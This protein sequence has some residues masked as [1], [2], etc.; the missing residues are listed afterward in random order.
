MTTA[1][2]ITTITLN[3]AIDQTLSIPRFTVG[4]VN[5]VERSQLDAGGKGV[6][7]AAALADYELPV[8]VTGF[9]GEEN[10]E[11]F[12][13]LFS[14]KGIADRFVRVAGMTR[15]GIKVTDPVARQ[16]T[17]INF[18]G[19]T[20]E[21][22]DLAALFETIEILA[23]DCDRF[24][25]S[26]SVPAGLGASIYRD[27]ITRLKALGKWVA[28]DTSG[29]P[30]AQALAAR[31]DLIKPNTA[32]LAELLGEHLGDE[33]A[34]LAGAR[35]L[36]HDYGIGT[37]VVSMGAEGALCLEGEQSLIAV[38]APVAVVSTV[39]AGD[40]LLAGMVAGAVRG[41][42]LADRARLATAFAMAAIGR[43]GAGL[44]SRSVIDDLMQRV[45][46]RYPNEDALMGTD[47]WVRVTRQNQRQLKEER[48]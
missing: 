21:S 9:L 6:N 47:D 3:P 12:R 27:L 29:E 20:P 37:V 23:S 19:T 7:V 11:I 33:Q 28:L 16:T 15:I 44:P 26:G 5:R 42:T 48:P 41:Y 17:D 22:G 34:T 14:R 2:A 13:R 10:D 43:L 46:V 31:P 45:T 30:L 38:P 1:V 36:S 8:A 18:P 39:G 24:I 40:A 35:R 32:E 4:A 25:L